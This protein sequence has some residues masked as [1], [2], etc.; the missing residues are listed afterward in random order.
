[1]KFKNIITNNSTIKKYLEQ[2]KFFIIKIKN[3]INKN[4]DNKNLFKDIKNISLI[5]FLSF[6]FLITWVNRV[7]LY[8]ENVL[9][10]VKSKT[11]SFTGFKKNFPCQIE[12]EKVSSENFKIFDGKIMV[13]SDNSLTVMNTFGNIIRNEK[14]S[15]SHPCL[16]LG[17][18]RR[19]EF[20]NRKSF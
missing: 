12:G 2:I 3:L 7:K 16:K 11:C 18:V 14:H 4:E 13:L 19:K 1:M 8:P 20:Q 6:L 15:F 5:L 10:W 17:N 9:I